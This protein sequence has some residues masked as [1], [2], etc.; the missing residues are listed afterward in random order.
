MTA[1]GIWCVLWL[2]T[3]ALTSA[4]PKSRQRLLEKTTEQNDDTLQVERDNQENILS[5]LLGDYDKV[6]ALAEGS[7]CGCKCVVRPLSASACQR[8]RDGHATPQDFYTV[9]T[10]TSG[11]HC[12][13]ACIAP[14]SAL[15][16]CEGDFRLK[17]LQQA[18]KDNI[19]LSTILELLEGSFYGMD[20]LKLHSVTTKL[21]DRMDTIEKMVLNNQTEEK[22][23]TRST[24]PN[25]QLLTTSPAT[26]PPQL[27]EKRTSLREQNDEA[28]AFQHIE[29]KYEEKF[30][31]DLL[32]SSGSDLNKAVAALQ[33]QERQGREKQPK[34]IVRGITY[35]KSD[36]V[37]ETDTEENYD[38]QSGDSPIDLFADEQLLHHK[39]RLFR[40]VIK[41]WS[42]RPKS[43]SEV[44]K[45]GDA[46]NGLQTQFTGLLD[47][48]LPIKTPTEP[49][50][51]R[52][53]TSRFTTDSSTG[54]ERT[55][56]TPAVMDNLKV[57]IPKEHNN[58]QTIV[59]KMEVSNAQ[60]MLVRSSNLGH[61]KTNELATAAAAKVVAAQPTLTEITTNETVEKETSVSSV[62]ESGIVNKKNL[63]ENASHTG[64]PLF[65]ME[66][67]TQSTFR[68][69][70]PLPTPHLDTLTVTESSLGS[71]AH[72]R[73]ATTIVTSPHVT[74]SKA[75]SVTYL[76]KMTP[77][78]TLTSVPSLMTTTKTTT[79]TT[80]TTTSKPGKRKYSINWD[81]EE[82]VVVE[83]EME[84]VKA[85]KTMVED[86][87]GEEPQRKSGMCKDT[88]ATISEPVTHNTYGRNE[89]AW[90]KD[91][92]A[93]DDKV[94]VTNYYYGNNLLE[95]R[96]MD[97]FKQGRFTNSY[98]L[99][100]N[101]IGTGH[102]VY[103]GAFYYNRAF[104]RDIIKYDLRLRYV[105]AWTMLYDA[106]FDN[107]DVSAWRWRGNSD[108]DLAVDESGLWVIYPAL[109]DEGF[110]QEMIVLSR[111]NPN[112]LSMKRETTWR[113]GLRRNHYGNCFIVCGVLYATDSYNQH[114]INLSYAFDTH[115]NTQVIP[116]LPFSNN[117]TYITQIDYN[118]KERVLYTWDN[119]HQVTYN[120]QFAYVDPL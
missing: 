39:A 89:G 65:S 72:T 120:I 76:P 8:I 105:A 40:P 42:V 66:S 112:D 106:V 2:P 119:G 12:K 85:V 29:S 75:D 83:E 117:Y 92:L 118:P 7:D 84:G 104:S 17:K 41:A 103:N 19:K 47:S 3:F 18:G 82:E 57:T 51:V 70:T 53:Q 37:D 114:D 91:P 38:N 16:P 36:P 21:L 79:T 44:S 81:E 1:M 24:S 15:N 5:Q 74:E 25:P 26:L 113:T 13:C 87:V 49:V 108:M 20:L 107:D 63:K 102:V 101:W 58:P 31:G 60:N 11:P 50:S 64:K 78:Q 115:T 33:E 10:I 23:N 93:Q 27:Q 68:R 14:P 88:L 6:K 56:A 9:E 28:A 99:P 86:S 77:K 34:I 96:N 54:D 116:H 95:F 62:T 46:R 30:V 71:T 22:S 48:A 43:K 67:L 110:L 4:A 98:K 90:M 59:K 35:Y 97:V 111:L 61:I 55:T 73:A 80:T 109:D 45:G 94:Y 52:T 100:Y 32:K 69:I